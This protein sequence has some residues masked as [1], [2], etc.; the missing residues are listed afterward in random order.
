MKT[1]YIPKNIIILFAQQIAALLA[2][3]VP[4]LSAIKTFVKHLSDRKASESFNHLAAYLEE[5]SSFG[6]ALAKTGGFPEDLI[7]LVQA[8]EPIGRIGLALEEAARALEERNS[9]FQQIAFSLFYPSLII[10]G[11]LAL[12]VFWLI[13]LLPT[14]QQVFDQVGADLPAVTLALLALSHFLRSYGIYL[15]GFFFL[16]FLI[17]LAYWRSEIGQ[18]RLSFLVWRFAPARKIIQPGLQ[19]RLAKTLAAL[20]KSGLSLLPSLEITRQAISFIPAREKLFWAIN[21]LKTGHSL[22][23][24]LKRTGLFS[25]FFLLGLASGEESGRLPD[26]LEKLGQ[27]SQDQ[28]QKTLKLLTSIL[29]PAATILTGLMVGFVIVSIFLPLIKLSSAIQ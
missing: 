17:L 4:L 13:F 23:A 8:S 14:F 24:S 20:L 16:A 5:G 10:L 25:P 15:T 6:E 27:Q 28:A 26:I 1:K 22:T 19:A 18:R 11:S 9:L 21:S 2:V 29:E 7:R 12:I 3:G